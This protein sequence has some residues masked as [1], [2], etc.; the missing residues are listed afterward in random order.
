[1]AHNELPIEVLRYLVPYSKDTGD[2]RWLNCQYPSWKGKLVGWRQAGYG[3]ARIL[4]KTVLIHRVAWALHHGAWPNSRLDHINGDKSDN[5]I[6]NLREVTAT[7][8]MQN[9]VV[10]KNNVTGI[11]GVTFRKDRSA[12]ISR[13]RVNGSL[14]FL[15]YFK[16]PLEAANAYTDAAERYFGEYSV[17]VSRKSPAIDSQGTRNGIA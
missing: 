6:E 1:M 17:H 15:G 10:G 14:K 3:K 16:D 9:R 7:Q 11:K 5:R 4:G 2:V 8:N 12:Y 13:I